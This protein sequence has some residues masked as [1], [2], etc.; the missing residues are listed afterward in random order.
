MT[1]MLLLVVLVFSPILPQNLYL[2]VFNFK[3]VYFIKRKTEEVMIISRKRKQRI[4]N[5]SLL[6]E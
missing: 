6:L 2:Y 1:K 5:Q 3:N 4:G